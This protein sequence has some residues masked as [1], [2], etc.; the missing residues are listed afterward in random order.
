M[1]NTASD[2][3]GSHPAGLEGA[4]LSCFHILLIN[5]SKTNSKV[6]LRDVNQPTHV[7]EEASEAPEQPDCQGE[8]VELRECV[9]L[10]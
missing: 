2:L 8:A 3:D 10:D 6:D 5:Y 1:P 4:Q 7:H 9:V